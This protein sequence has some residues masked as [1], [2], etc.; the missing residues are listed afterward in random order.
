LLR[1]TGMNQARGNVDVG[2][3]EIG[4]VFLASNE[5]LPEEPVHVAAVLA[6]TVRRGPVED[7]RPVDVYDAV[8]ALIA[9]LD[10]LEIGDH[11][12]V[13]SSPPGWHGGRTATV[14][15]DGHTVG[16]VG[17]VASNVSA[18]HDIEGRV[19]GFEVDLGQLLDA[20]R[21][22]RAYVAPSPYPAASIDLAFVLD[23]G[24]AAAD[25]VATLRASAPDL[26]ED[27]STF[28]EFRADDF[29]AGRR[30][31]AFRLR[32]RA[33][34]RTLKDADL[35]TLRQQAIAAVKTTHQGD[36]RG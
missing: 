5:L 29:G 7:D 4:R 36:L 6:G 32:Y 3:F 24:V 21:R 14:E 22:D 11:R 12:L 16:W 18:D 30:S 2:L 26:L 13:A 25:V 28:D 27:V 33:P 9:L 1:V 8:D 10:A 23:E 17:E 19:V 20:P 15:I 35:D 34:D 31:L